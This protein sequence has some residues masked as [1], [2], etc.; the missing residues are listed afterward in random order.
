MSAQLA[1]LQLRNAQIALHGD[2]KNLLL[3]EDERMAGQVYRGLSE[4]RDS[5]L[6]QKAKV[7]WLKEG[8][9]NSQYFHS[10]MK[11]RRML[12][13]VLSIEDMNSNMQT[14]LDGIKTAFLEYYG[15]LLG[16]HKSVKKVH[17]PT[18]RNGKTVNDARA[19]LLLQPV[20]P[21]EVKE[22]LFSIPA[23]KTPGPDGFSSQFFK[24]AYEVIRKDV[25]AGVIEYFQSG[26]L[27]KQRLN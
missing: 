14:T 10:H 15:N 20:I 22:A 4:A 1:Q 3:Q 21:Q 26:K 18:I 16:T 25:E 2:P 5:F 17:Y 9:S 8:D 11:E 13:R 19:C 24:D 7:H 23:T 27:L 6:D 12:N